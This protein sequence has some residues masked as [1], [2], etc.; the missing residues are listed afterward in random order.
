M[1]GCASSFYAPQQPVA[2]FLDTK[3]NFFFLLVVQNII[4]W[5]TCVSGWLGRFNWQCSSS[6]RKER[7]SKVQMI[8]GVLRLRSESRLSTAVSFPT[9]ISL[10]RS[11][12]SFLIFLS[13]SG[14]IDRFGS[15]LPPTIFSLFTIANATWRRRTTSSVSIYRWKRASGLKLILASLRRCVYTPFVFVFFFFFFFLP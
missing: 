15:L 5:P 12:F 11:L 7:N 4:Q 6:S 2:A 8:M 10:R 3:K 1:C 9:Q 13:S 14:C